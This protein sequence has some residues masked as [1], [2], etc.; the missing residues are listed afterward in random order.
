MEQEFS[1]ARGWKIFCYIACVLFIAAAVGMSYGVLIEGK[2]VLLAY[3]IPFFIWSVYMLIRIWKYKLI[4]SDRQITEIHA[5]TTIVIH[6][7][8]IEAF[9][10]DGNILTIF[11]RQKGQ[12]KIRINGYRYLGNYRGLINWLSYQF[13]ELNHLAY[14]KETQEILANPD[15][16]FTTGEK[17]VKFKRARLIT[18]VYNVI[19][20]GFIATPYIDGN[21][22]VNSIMLIYPFVGILILFLNRGVILLDTTAKSNHPNIGL[23]LV[24]PPLCMAII[25]L[26]R[27]EVLDYARVWMPALVIGAVLFGLF[28]RVNKNT[29]GETYKS[30]YILIVIIIACYAFGGTIIINCDLDRSVPAITTA[31]VES[32][33][34]TTEKVTTYTLTLGPWGHR[35]QNEDVDIPGS[36]YKTISPG[37]I[38]NVNVKKGFFNIPWFYISR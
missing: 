2:P 5:F 28:S 36:L 10:I 1:L 31:K 18:R 6:R 17:A 15:F 37:D 16:G 7:T 38:V 30:Q 33:F 11:P 32:Q 24:M 22:T 26:L 3:S 19:S 27:Y 8:D 12:K 21:I 25:V 29:A 13:N 4:I 23:G 34:K 9:R 35:K 20:F 14:V